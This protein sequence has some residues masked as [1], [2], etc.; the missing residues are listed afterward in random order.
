METGPE[1]RS[2]IRSE[3]PEAAVRHSVPGQRRDPDPGSVARELETLAE[4]LPLLIARD[5]AR[6]PRW[7][8][9]AFAAQVAAVRSLLSAA[10]SIH[11]LAARS[12][13]V[14]DGERLDVDSF[15]S[16][17]RRLA[18][19]ATAVA[20]AIRWLELQADSDLPG[21]PEILRRGSFRSMA[22]IGHLDAALWFG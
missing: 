9:T 20:F 5:D 7:V 15:E 19:D 13:F 14:G 17:A 16:A 6:P 21:W 4:A 8:S 3:I 10:V 12:V 18:G 22:Q 2:E 11:D 1:I